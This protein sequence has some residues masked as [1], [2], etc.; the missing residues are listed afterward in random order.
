MANSDPWKIDEPDKG[1]VKVELES[2]SD[3]A[4]FVNRGLLNSSE[5]IFRGQ[6]D[7]WPLRSSLIR[8]LGETDRGRQMSSS[9]PPHRS[10]TT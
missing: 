9:A 5:Y 1:Q 7:S 10:L 6:R 3:F 8:T 4:A 2:W